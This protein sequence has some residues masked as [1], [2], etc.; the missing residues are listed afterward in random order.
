MSDIRDDN[1]L[2]FEIVYAISV[3]GYA[4]IIV[5][6]GER[7]MCIFDQYL[8]FMIRLVVFINMFIFICVR[9]E[10]LGTFNF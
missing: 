4:N 3:W 7:H 8:T 9:S 5:F 6:K 2:N 10:G 1:N